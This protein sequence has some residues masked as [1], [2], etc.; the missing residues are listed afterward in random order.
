MPV[1]IPKKRNACVY[2]AKHEQNTEAPTSQGRVESTQPQGTHACDVLG[3]YT[4]RHSYTPPQKSGQYFAPSQVKNVTIRQIKLD[5][6]PE[7][8]G[9]ALASKMYCADKYGVRIQALPGLCTYDYLARTRAARFF[10][11]SPR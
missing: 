8:L 10:N 9:N 4:C 3:I 1:W 6:F 2:K 5:K 7:I 11:Q